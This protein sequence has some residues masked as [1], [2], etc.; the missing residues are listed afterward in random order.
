MQ[1]HDC[2]KQLLICT[3]NFL[4]FYSFTKIRALQCIIVS[5]PRHTG[6]HYVTHR[7]HRMQKNRFGVLCP[8]VLFMEIAPSPPEHG[9]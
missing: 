1:W 4:E 2:I 9:K 8:G 7:S 5:H 6:M 3:N